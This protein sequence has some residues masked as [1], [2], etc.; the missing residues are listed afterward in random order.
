MRCHSASRIFLLSLFAIVVS[1]TTAL[2]HPVFAQ[3]TAEERARERS[4]READRVRDNRNLPQDRRGRALGR[5]KPLNAADRRRLDDCV[6]HMLMGPTKKKVKV[7]GHEFNCKRHSKWS[8]SGDFYKV[9]GQLSHHLTAR[10]DDQ[11]NYSFLVSAT[12]EIGGLTMKTK[13]G[14]FRKIVNKFGGLG[15]AKVKIGTWY[16]DKFLQATGQAVDGSWQSSS[17]LIIGTMAIRI[18]RSVRLAKASKRG[19]PSLY[20]FVDRPGNDIRNVTLQRGRDRPEFCQ[21]LCGNTPNCRA[22]TLNKNEVTRKSVCWMKGRIGDVVL[23]NRTVS[24]IKASRSRPGRGGATIGQPGSQS[25][26][27]RRRGSSFQ[28]RRIPGS[29]DPLGDRQGMEEEDEP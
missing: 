26:E 21:N 9:E 10:P 6:D 27:A 14:G 20:W 17:A 28:D 12:G 2:S 1:F 5:S 8:K 18:G 22:W 13:R 16:A 11:V 15:N 3:K 19:G 4:D 29:R 23:N 24:G 25:G 7:Q